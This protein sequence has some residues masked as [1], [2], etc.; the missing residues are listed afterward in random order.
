MRS[1]TVACDGDVDKHIGV[2]VSKEIQFGFVSMMGP[3][4]CICKD[5]EA[6]SL[7]VCIKL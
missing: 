2:Q 5:R 3:C 4:L 1:I 6:F 7:K